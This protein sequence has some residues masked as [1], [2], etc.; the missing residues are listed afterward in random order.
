MCTR[1]WM[2][3]EVKGDRFPEIGIKGSYEPPD[4]D[5][6]SRTQLLWKSNAHSPFPEASS[7]GETF[8]I[9][10]SQPFHMYERLS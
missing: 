4:T 5:P 10:K 9:K 8:G 7:L 6:G 1:V 3:E 2:P